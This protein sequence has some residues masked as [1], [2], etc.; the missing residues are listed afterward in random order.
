MEIHIILKSP[1][2]S[3]IKKQTKQMNSHETRHLIFETAF[4]TLHNNCYIFLLWL[5]QK[6]KLLYRNNSR[7]SIL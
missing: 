2:F 7:Y 3:S 5:L 1:I 6:L 4:F